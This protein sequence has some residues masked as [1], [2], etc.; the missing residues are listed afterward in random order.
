MEEICIDFE[1]ALKKKEITRVI[2]CSYERHIYGHTRKR[3]G[4][5]PLFPSFANNDIRQE[6]IKLRRRFCSLEFLVRKGICIKSRRT[7]KNW[8]AS[9]LIRTG[10]CK[11]RDDKYNNFDEYERDYPGC[12]VSCSNLYLKEKTPVETLTIYPLAAFRSA[13]I[14]LYFRDLINY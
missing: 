1:G 13:A 5:Q 2:F 4:R 12:R 3:R 10:K 7:R 9:L 14:D 8:K 11:R 6:G